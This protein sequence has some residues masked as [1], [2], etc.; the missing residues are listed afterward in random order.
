MTPLLIS[1]FPSGPLW[2]HLYETHRDICVSPDP[3]KTPRGEVN[4]QDHMSHELTPRAGQTY[5]FRMWFSLIIFGAL[6]GLVLLPVILSLA[7][8]PGFPLQEADEEWMSTAIRSGYEYTSVYQ[9]RFDRCL[10]ALTD[11]LSL[12]GLSLRTMPQSTATSSSRLSC[13]L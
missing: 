10:L 2:D 11:A 1:C 8:G 7:G 9:S 3:V 4:T 13:I 6:H 5:Y 12:A